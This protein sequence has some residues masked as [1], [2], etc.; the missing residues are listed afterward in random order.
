VVTTQMMLD[1]LVLG[2]GVRVFVGAVQF[3]R[4][5]PPRTSR[6]DRHDSK[7]TAHS[8]RPQA[9]HRIGRADRG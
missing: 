8:G 3:A 2:L 7:A 5:R 6:H 1:L 4:G 9:R